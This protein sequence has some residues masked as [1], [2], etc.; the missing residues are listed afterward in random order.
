MRTPEI[1]HLVKGCDC[2]N[3]E[4]RKMEQKYLC[5]RQDEGGVHI[6][7]KT[8]RLEDVWGT[9]GRKIKTTEGTWTTKLLF[10]STKEILDD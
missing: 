1:K 3:Y 6:V 2:V 10:F 5:D 4:T 8:G 9:K 7:R